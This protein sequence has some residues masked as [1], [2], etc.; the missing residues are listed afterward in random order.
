MNNFFT[1]Y[2]HLLTYPFRRN[3]KRASSTTAVYIVMAILYALLIV[4]TCVSLYYLTPVFNAYGL[5]AELHATLMLACGVVVLVFAFAPALSGLFFSSDAQFLA[6]LPIKSQTIF[7]AKLAVIYTTELAIV[8][9]FIVPCSIVMGISANLGVLFY[10]SIILSV[11]LLPA[12]PLFLIVILALP[13][14]YFIGL[15]KNKGALTSI[16]LIV[17][18]SVFFIVYFFAIGAVGEENIENI[19]INA[20]VLASAE[21]ITLLANIFFPFSSLTRFA[22]LSNKTVFGEL[23]LPFAPI[24]N[25]AVFTLFSAVVLLVAVVISAKV[26]HKTVSKMAESGA[27]DKKKK[28]EYKSAKSPTGALMAKEWRELVRTPAFALQ[29]LLGIIMSPLLV[30][31][32]NFTGAEIATVP[33]F[34]NLISYVS[35]LAIAMMGCGINVGAST[36]ISREGKNFV[37]MKTIPVPYKT[38]VTAKLRLYLIISSVTVALSLVVFGVMAFNLIHLIFGA[39]FLFAYNYAFN[40]FAVLFDL[41]HI[42]LNWV[43]PN[44]IVKQSANVSVPMFVGM[45]ALIVAIAITAL[46]FVLIGGILGTILAYLTLT[47]IFLALGIFLRLKTSQNAHRYIDKVTA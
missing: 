37:F 8:L 18:F 6:T 32:M 9:L 19:D 40:N 42:K 7:L 45:G 10:A 34:S 27:G 31:I 16:I 36:C 17:L 21:T 12:I 44:E 22:T 39:I 23:P 25:I 46:F 13:I 26:Y 14:A 1:L 43:L 38:Q 11:L 20:L 35:V 29:C 33:G 2:K 5:V 47:V 30:F 4:S 24:V 28:A 15:F 3:G 41:T